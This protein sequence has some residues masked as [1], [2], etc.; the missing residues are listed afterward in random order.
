M[1]FLQVL[2]P[3][4]VLRARYLFTDVLRHLYVELC[5]SPFFLRLLSKHISCVDIFPKL[6]GCLE[7]RLARPGLC[8]LFVCVRLIQ[9]WKLG[10]LV[11]DTKVIHENKGWRHGRSPL[12]SLATLDKAATWNKTATWA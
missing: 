11:S 8:S 5:V 6:L 12:D 7:I 10:K 9:F 3:E 2:S 1:M 4:R